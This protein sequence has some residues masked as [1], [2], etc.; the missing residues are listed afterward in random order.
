MMHDPGIAV[1]GATLAREAPLAPAREALLATVEG[2]A[3][4][5]IRDDEVERARTSLL[6]SLEKVLLD[7]GA[8]VRWLAEF[9]AVG[10]WRLLYLYRDRLTAVTA[11]DVRRVAAAYF[12]PANRVLGAFVPTGRPDRAEIPPRPALEALLADYRGAQ[13][14]EDGEAFDPTPENIERRVLRRTLANG[15]RAALLPK[16]TR[17]GR[18]VAQLVLHWGDEASTMHRHA[19]CTLAGGML[20]RGTTRRTRAELRAEMDRLRATI[21]VGM[22]G[23]SIEV[24]RA[25]L[26][27]ALALAAEM[28]RAPRFD[29]A[30]FEELKRATITAA[31][32]GRGDPAARASERLARHLGP[33]PRGHWFYTPTVE[34]RIEALS[35]AT[36][37]DAR[38]CYAELLGATGAQFAAVGDFDPEALAAQVEAL[39]GD[40]KTPHPYA[41]IPARYFDTPPL[42][43]RIATPDK[44]NAVLRAGLNLRL[45]DAHP[46]YPAL[47]LG[48]WLLG[49]NSDAR[50]PVRVREKEGLS[51]STYSWLNAGQLDEAGQFGVAAIY[52][53][54]N[55]ERVERAVREE[56]ARALADGF[57]EAELARAKRALLEARRVA[58]AQ[59]RALVARLANYLFLGR[60]FEWDAAFERRIAALGA[61]DV[62][63]A[64]A[65]H[66][67]PARLSVFVAGDFR[68]PAGAAA[69]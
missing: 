10:D 45:S 3:A 28:L 33:Y 48:N 40:W 24:R 43:E 62:R 19:A 69:R 16:K 15:I 7:S 54:Q 23:A 35:Q 38:R 65:R 14:L 20:A 32:A 27:P 53:P 59:D 55:R 52:A 22:D 39:F 66:I 18:V 30:E 29:P 26:Q 31:Q 41:R 36:L 21:S 47:V 60:T 13:A 51:Y 67:D 42:A 46:D 11:D 4:D 9:H 1:F 25:Q 37:E 12:K 58:R 61:E 63:A 8:L 2:A 5:P 49:G 56:L 34:E 57:D 17:G 50:L 44:A 6:A 64:L 68:E